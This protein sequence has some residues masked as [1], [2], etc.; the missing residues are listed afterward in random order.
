MTAFLKQ[1][2][3]HYH[4]SENIRGMC[5]I[6]PNKRSITFF[7]K[8]L[9]EIC[10][11][12][13][14][15]AFAPLCL[16]MN[17]FFA[18]MS[19]DRPADRMGQMLVLYDCYKSLNPEAEPLDE[20][21]FWG[22]VLL[23]DFAEVDKYLVNAR[24][25]FANVAEFKEMQGSFD[26][27]DPGQKAAMERFL[28][29][30]KDTGEY[31][32]RFRRIWDI[33]CPLYESF[34]ARLQ[35]LGLSGEGRIYRNLAES[36]E[37]GSIADILGKHYPDTV[38]FVFVGLNALNNCEKKVMR[39]MRDAG[40]AEFCWDFSS[41]EIRDEANRSSFFMGPNTAEFPQA[42]EPDPEGPGRPAVQV[43]SVPSSVGQAKLLDR[44]FASAEGP[45]GINTA[46]VLPDEGLLLPVLNSIPEDVRDVNVTMGYPMKGSEF[47]ALMKDIAALQLN[48]RD[49]NGEKFFYH[50]Y[51]WGI[52]SNSI[53]RTLLDGPGQQTVSKIRSEA[54]YYIPRGSFT[55]NPVLEAIFR[56]AED[57]PAYE[58]ELILTLA[59]LL[60]EHGGM[61]MELQF[62]MAWYKALT[63]LQGLS[64][65]IQPKT[66]F[67]LI[68]QMVAGTAVPF[69]GEPL[70]G[71]QIMG[72]L[73]TRA[74]DFDNLVIL[75]CNE[76]MFP[77]RS[78]AA[79]FIPAELRKGFGLPTYE[80]QDAVWAYY[81]YRLIQRAKKV[82]LVFDS[83]T[84]MSRS[85]EESRYIRQLEML[86]GFDVKRFTVEAPVA[87]SEDD[88]QIPKTG[89]HLAVME[90]P[91]FSLSATAL[92]NY[93][94]CPARFY[95]SKIQQL[96]AAGEVSESLDAGMI[97]NAL[98]H[99]MENLYKGRAII[100]KTYLEGLLHDESRIRGL[101]AA[102]IMTQLH[103]DEIEG[104]NLVFQELIVRYVL[105]VLKTDLA[106]LK[107]G[108]K[109]SFRI[110]G[111]EKFKEKK[112]AGMRLLGYIDR[113][114]SFED[115][116]VRVVDY[117]TGKVTEQETG[118]SDATADE[119]VEA[120]FAPGNDRRP[121]IALQL[122]LY[123]EFLEGDPAVAGKQV[124]NC[125]YQT[126]SIFVKEPSSMP[127]SGRFCD[128]MKDKVAD[129]LKEIRDPEQPWTRTANA[130]DCEY[131]DFK[132][133]CGR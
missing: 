41:A 64:P 119:V 37:S 78:V 89:E 45:V 90:D 103:T 122:Y 33:L 121:K 81:F 19:E 125:I 91:S 48:I 108:G 68:D 58:R 62:C 47:H 60:K 126:N 86:Y 105:Q 83:R 113:L 29:Q 98:H 52:F 131:C 111:L 59:P 82:W 43:V 75:S 22:D 56:P 72:P 32:E 10:A 117:K 63:R 28:A 94:V 34:N 79:S 66:W 129:L 110:L 25:I 106:L 133:I 99:T 71:L 21:I 85:G 77:R 128:L 44:I 87:P 55:G 88:S 53:V 74:L 3:L 51:V 127:R 112:I 20:F 1:V 31:K 8:Y 97:G 18:G 115:G 9:G 73:E 109:S 23:G 132:T 36:L 30:F 16:T 102:E 92:Q 84:E 67:R 123:D 76:G 15:P 54:R 61:Q 12:T 93:L 95:Y 50:K 118:I 2:A 114:D 101:V 65:Q 57:V 13:H 49:K 26:F 7:K 130:K 6:F 69:Q 96:S 5:F 17:D 124:L 104:R 39:K 11:R 38:K 42:F 120:L 27:L 100:E 40:L 70:R 4:P 14:T 24:H 80:Y 46:V 35:E 116:T 107:S